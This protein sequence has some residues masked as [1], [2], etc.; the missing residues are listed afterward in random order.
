MIVVG[1][2]R[3]VAPTSSLS[4]VV[5]VFDFR[6]QSLESRTGASHAVRCWGKLRHCEARRGQIWLAHTSGGVNC[7]TG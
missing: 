7:E 2:E 4:I 3:E 5:F 6:A 1:E